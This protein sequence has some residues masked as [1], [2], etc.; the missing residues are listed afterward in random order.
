MARP[1][2]IVRIIDRLNVG[3]PT[4]HVALLTRRLE[5]RGY[6]TTLVKGCVAPGEREM[7]EVISAEGVHPVAIPT[8][9][10]EVAWRDDPASLAALVGLIRRVRPDIVHT[11]KSKAGL[12][13][14]IAARAAGVPVS[15]HTFH[16]HVFHGYFG[17]AK[18]AAI[19]GLERILAAHTD[20]VVSVSPS[21]RRELLGYGIAPPA[22]IHC[23]PLGLDLDRFRWCDGLRGA[24]RREIG[25]FPDAP[26]AGLIARLAPVKGVEVFL[27]A[28]AMTLKRLPQAR[29]LVVG[30]G[31]PRQGL[32]AEA[33]RLGIS[34]AVRFTGYRSDTDTIYASLDLAVLSSYNEGLPVSLIE[35][36][37]AGCYVAATRVGGVPDLVKDE[38]LGLLAL[39]GDH[40]A[41]SGAMTRS[42][43]E[44]RRVSEEDRDWICQRY[45]IERL[46][47]DLDGLYRGL[48]KRKGYRLEAF[49]EETGV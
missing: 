23:I 12:L 30:D 31:W 20:A 32:E 37:A 45:G 6:Q 38:R 14:R 25:V 49:R 5:A 41:L 3:G 8:L 18:S 48:L 33:Q 2:R 22:R 13:G 28:A 44:R 29:F 1:I 35:A 4:Q 10:R 11:H 24:F 19:V 34:D 39:P 46:V 36:L 7:A 9:G 43:V 42:L 16:G 26:L 27:R 21:Q 47:D 15:V 17:P 40:E